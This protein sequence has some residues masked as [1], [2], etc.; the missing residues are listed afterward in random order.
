MYLKYC[1]PAHDYSGY[2]EA[3][4]HDIGALYSVAIPLITEI[5]R[6]CLEITDFGKLGKIAKDA[7]DNVGDYKGKIIHTTPN[8]F[9]VKREDGKYNIARVF[10]E[11]DKLPEDFIEGCQMVDEIWTGSEW[12]KQAIINSG[13]KVPVKIIPQAI[14]TSVDRGSIEPFVIGHLNDYKFYSIFEWTA[15]KNPKVLLQAYWLEFENELDVSLSIKTYVDNFS[16]EKRQEILSNI[17]SWKAELNLKRYAPI[18]LF[19]GLLNRH[20]M[21][22][23][24]KTFDC[25]V[26]THRGE[27]WGIPQMEA[28]FMGKPVI[29]TNCGGIHE[30]LVD[31][32][33]AYLLPYTLGQVQNTRNVVWYTPDQ[34][35]ANV[36]I[37]D[38][39][40]AMRRVFD[41]REEAASVGDNGRQIVEGMFSL[42]KIGK[43]M[44][45]R[46]EELELL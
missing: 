19:N 40:A 23:F 36:A 22:R 33:D 43:H 4:R 41:K 42:E 27:G 29:S 28:L 1:G 15:R 45:N 35:W 11:T 21:Y 46:L 37:E 2:G 6:F 25:F 32:A 10:W 39:R 17:D 13:I 8:I 26:S 30:F 44:R 12:N 20:Q 14:D 24:H 3:V 34:K 7:V 38:V 5:P 31:K 16:R 18:Y 9:Q